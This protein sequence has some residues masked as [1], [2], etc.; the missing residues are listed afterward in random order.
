MKKL[1][2]RLLDICYE[3]KLHHLGSYFSCLHIID[4]IYKNKNKDDIFILSNEHAVVEIYV[5]LEKNYGID[6]KDILDQK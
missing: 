5:V 4:D 2:R 1:Y 3:N 6:A